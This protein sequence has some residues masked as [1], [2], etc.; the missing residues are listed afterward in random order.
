MTRMAL[1]FTATP[2][3]R[4]D[5][6]ASRARKSA[7][8]K[9]RAHRQELRPALDG[10]LCD[11]FCAAMAMSALLGFTAAALLAHGVAVESSGPVA[12]AIACLLG[13]VLFQVV[14]RRHTW[15]VLVERA[16]A[17]GLSE[18]QAKQEARETIKRW[19]S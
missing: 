1:D 8:E 3:R 14:E 18:E 11:R 6:P 13:A 5:G 17:A 4:E 7:T 2:P 10:N 9:E 12:L 16:R 19:L 15:K